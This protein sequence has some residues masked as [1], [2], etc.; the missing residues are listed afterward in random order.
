MSE[1]SSTARMNAIATC[2]FDA[3]QMSAIK[4]VPRSVRR[5]QQAVR[6]AEAATAATRT[7]KIFQLPAL[8][9]CRLQKA[10]ATQQKQQLKHPQHHRALRELTPRVNQTLRGESP[11]PNWT[12]FLGSGADRA[13][14]FFG[15]ALTMSVAPDLAA[16]YTKVAILEQQ[17][18]LK[19]QEL[20]LVKHAQALQLPGTVGLQALVPAQDRALRQRAA[21]VSVPP[22]DDDAL[23]DK[24]F[25]LV[26]SGDYFYVAGVC[27]R[28]RGRY[29]THCYK[30]ADEK[31]K[32]EAT[33][34][35]EEDQNNQ[36]S[37]KLRTGVASAVITAD[38]LQMAFNDKLTVA[39]LRPQLFGHSVAQLSL[40]PI[41]VFALAKQY[42]L[43]WD[44]EHCLWAVLEDR[45]DLVQWL[46]SRGCP[47]NIDHIFTRIS[48]LRRVD[49]DMLKWLRTKT[50]AW[51][52]DR[53]ASLLRAALQIEKYPAAE[54]LRQQGAAWPDSFR[55]SKYW[56]VYTQP[57]VKYALDHG[58]AWGVWDC[59]KLLPATVEQHML[60]CNQQLA[61]ELLEWAH[62]NGCPCTCGQAQS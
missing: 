55:I 16:L 25:G 8:L 5:S 11:A 54:W 46:R 61:K 31:L 57:I 37:S 42:D 35:E 9:C 13:V 50:G 17:L 7:R 51:A 48:S 23:L 33:E 58:A 27:R 47:W 40:E 3:A 44:V 60:P 43:S 39:Q 20:Q 4:L 53:K 6:V 12:Y 32:A 38:R 49:V 2:N 10:C 36:H 52:A 26:G 62:A 59:Q 29:I 19:D 14:I 22:L 45:L 18:A 21:V 1:D 24:I 28:W 15:E 30:A 34:E 41:T 56:V